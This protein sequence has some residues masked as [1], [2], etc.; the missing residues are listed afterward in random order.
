MQSAEHS[1]KQLFAEHVLLRVYCVACGVV[2]EESS[3]FENKLVL[4]LRER[5]FEELETDGRMPLLW[6]ESTQLIECLSESSCVVEDLVERR[7][8]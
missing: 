7:V 3:F 4:L 2:N 8:S 1:F 5:Y 6:T